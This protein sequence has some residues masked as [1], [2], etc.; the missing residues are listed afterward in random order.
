[1][2]TAEDIAEHLE[3]SKMTIYRMIHDPENPLGAVKIGGRYKIPLAGYRR[4]LDSIGLSLDD[5]PLS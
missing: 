5:K 3:V 2:L 4:Y 1:M